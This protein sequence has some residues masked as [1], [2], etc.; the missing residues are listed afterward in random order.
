MIKVIGEVLKEENHRI[1]ETLAK[2]LLHK[3]LLSITHYQKTRNFKWDKDLNR[4]FTKKTHKWHLSIQKTS[5]LQMSQG[6]CKSQHRS[7]FNQLEW[8]NPTQW[9]CC[10]LGRVQQASLIAWTHADVWPLPK[11]ADT[12]PLS[13]PGIW[14]FSWLSGFTC[15]SDKISD[16][17]ERV[18]VG[19]LAQW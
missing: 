11:A 14:F 4:Y 9:T 2:P 1:G 19:D 13:N 5:L 18:R 10:R 16:K 8:P 6:T 17:K 7:H 12:F 3:N 15:C